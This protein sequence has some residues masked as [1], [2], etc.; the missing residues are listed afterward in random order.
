MSIVTTAPFPGRVCPW[1]GKSASGS[2]P[3]DAGKKPPEKGD[4]N[5]CAYCVG[6]SIFTDSGGGLRRPTKVE[7]R[8]LLGDPAVI[9]AQREVAENW[10]GR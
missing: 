7:H 5:V 1:C 3:I 6:L 4:L 8:D 2:T 9:D 10:C